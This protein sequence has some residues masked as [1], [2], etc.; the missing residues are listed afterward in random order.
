MLFRSIQG[1]LNYLMT[2]TKTA[3]EDYT[4]GERL[5]DAKVMVRQNIDGRQ[6]LSEMPLEVNQI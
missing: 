3:S 1:Y 6:M 2:G 4:Y 5:V